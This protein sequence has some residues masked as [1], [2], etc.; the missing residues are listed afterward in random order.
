M[1]DGDT[2]SLSLTVTASQH[3]DVSHLEPVLDAISIPRAGPGRPKKRLS[4]LRINQAYGACKPRKLVQRRGIQCACPEHE[5]AKKHRL[6]HGSR[7]RSPSPFNPDDFNGR[8]V[9]ER[10]INRL[11]DFHAVATRCDKRGVHSPAVVTAAVLVI[12]L[13]W[14]LSVRP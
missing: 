3:V 8:N 14:E 10:V 4:R 7:G 2:R 12:W 13:P 6:K 5:D 9:V 1:W 11:K